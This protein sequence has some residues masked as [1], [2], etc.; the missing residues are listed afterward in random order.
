MASKSSRLTAYPNALVA[1]PARFSCH[2][3][4]HPDACDRPIP[5]TNSACTDVYRPLMPSLHDILVR[6]SS[7]LP[8][9][10]IENHEQVPPRIFDH[11]AETNANLKRPDDHLSACT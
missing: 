8:F 9:R 11:R 2:N 4:G 7:Q 3:K 6:I 10:R 5:W 1:S